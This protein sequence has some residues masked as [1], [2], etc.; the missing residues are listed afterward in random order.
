VEATY[1]AHKAGWEVLL[2][3]K[4][5]SA[6]AKGLCDIYLPVDVAKGTEFIGKLGDVQLIIPALED[7]EV[8][9]MLS[10][11]ASAEDL[12]LAFDPAAYA[13][14]SSKIRSDQLFA[15][16][17]IPVPLPWPRG[18]FPLIVKPSDASGS[19]GVRRIDRA[20][21]FEH[22]SSFAK[23]G[24]DWV[25]QEF[26]EGPS[27]SLE[28][29][30][31]REGYQTLQVTDLEMDAHY[32]CKRV[33]APSILSE[34]EMRQ[35]EK[36]R[37][38]I[39]RALNVKGIMDV[40]VILHEGTLK[41]LEIDARLPSQTPTAV[42][43]STGINMVE[44]LGTLFWKGERP[45]VPQVSSGRGVVYEHLK[46]SPGRMEI[47][48]EHIMASAGPLHLIPGFFGSTEAITNYRPGASDWI[49][50]LINTG[51]NLEEAWDRRCQVLREIGKHCFL[52]EYVDPS[53]SL[54]STRSK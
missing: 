9:S 3:D 23:G 11:L 50:T 31:F 18:S 19:K 6:P 7:R 35:F 24:K 21:E 33:K 44:M 15:E 1:L 2:V 20:D 17:G 28:V 4:D 52:S 32:D 30:G 8:L 41:V 39:A 16:L 54:P 10:R 34:N 48:G 53:P 46:I 5:P 49:A 51:E 42:Y 36:L 25:I 26:L 38:T 37:L 14:S 40:E 12:P 27:F 13:I 47:C 43:L 45:L 22:W 29:L